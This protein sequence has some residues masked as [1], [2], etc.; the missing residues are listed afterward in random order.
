ML[1]E[2]KHGKKEDHAL[3]I[4]YR[5]FYNSNNLVT[6]NRDFWCV[7]TECIGNKALSKV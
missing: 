5:K 3:G 6:R 2:L 4:L 7:S 1:G